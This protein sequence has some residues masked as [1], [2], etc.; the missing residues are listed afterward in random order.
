MH[1]L[2]QK[3]LTLGIR[4]DFPQSYSRGPSDL[5]QHF[6]YRGSSHRHKGAASHKI[7]LVWLY[8]WTCSY[9]DYLPSRRL[10]EVWG[11]GVGRLLMEKP[12]FSLDSAG[13]G[14]FSIAAHGRFLKLP[15][16]GA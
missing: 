11:G 9:A 15:T 13:F 12:H 7:G 2:I 4:G 6:A 1:I 16:E 10:V 5:V 14:G 8:R 3:T